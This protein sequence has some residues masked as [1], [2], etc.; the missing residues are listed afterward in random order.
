MTEWPSRWTC[1]S[2]APKAGPAS[3]ASPDAVATRRNDRRSPGWP[4]LIMERP[5]KVGFSSHKPTIPYRLGKHGNT[6]YQ[7]RLM[8]TIVISSD[9]GCPAAWAR[10]ASSSEANGGL[11]PPKLANNLPLPNNSPEWSIASVTPSV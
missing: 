10:T 8:A 1:L 5:G 7:L 11:F 6:I 3:G 2:G 4:I 9:C